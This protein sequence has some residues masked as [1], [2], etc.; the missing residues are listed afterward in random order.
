[1]SETGR[2]NLFYSY[3][4]EDDS[5][6][7]RL[8]AALAVLRDEGVIGEWHDRLIVPSADWRRTISR[9]LEQSHIV[10]FLV[11]PAFMR[12]DYCR[13]VE[14]RQAIDLHWQRRCRI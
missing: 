3:A 10:L 14:V 9:Q 2:I 5:S 4:H 8:V 13:S 11:S 12:S 1:M 7:E 6:R